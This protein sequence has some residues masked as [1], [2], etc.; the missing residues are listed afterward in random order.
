MQKEVRIDYDTYV[1]FHQHHPE[2]LTEP[3]KQEH[4][5]ERRVAHLCALF[6]LLQHI[7]LET[8]DGEET[9]FQL[10]AL[11][12]LGQG[13]SQGLFHTIEVLSDD[14]TTIPNQSLR[15]DPENN[16]KEETI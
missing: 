3:K 15:K 14:K 5:G 4:S 7:N 10:N 8:G 16:E 11:G 2:T 13:I 12:E 6:F 1:P 9:S